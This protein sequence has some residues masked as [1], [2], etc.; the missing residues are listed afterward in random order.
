MGIPIVASWFNAT[1]CRCYGLQITRRY[2]R[3]SK[4]IRDAHAVQEAGAVA[5]V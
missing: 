5:L 1:K 2:K 4:L 3:R